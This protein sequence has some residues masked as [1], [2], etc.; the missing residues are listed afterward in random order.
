M[1]KLLLD[2]VRGHPDSTP[3]LILRLFRENFRRYMWRYAL[4]L[5]LMA[6][7]SAAT[8][9]SAWLIRDVINDVFVDQKIHMV[10]IFGGIFVAISIIKGFS[11]YGQTV[12]L[13]RIGNSIVAGMQ[14]QIFG[15]ILQLGMG[16]FEK[17]HSSQLIK[18]VSHNA[19]AARDLMNLIAT[20]FG[21]DLLT[22][23]GLVGV[24]IALD[25]VM[26]LL[27]LLIAPPIVVFMV[28]VVRR[29]RKLAAQEI[30]TGAA[31]IATAQE[32]TSGIRIIKSF[33][34]EEAMRERV[35]RVVAAVQDRANRM[36]RV[37]ASTGPLME[38]LGGIAIGLVI[39]YAGWQTIEAGRSPGDY[40][41]F[42]VAF[43][44]AYE[45]AKR[46]ARFRINLERSVVGVR[47]MYELIDSPP[48]EVDSPDAVALD[49][50][51]GQLA[52]IDVRF[53]YRAQ[54]PVLDGVSLEAAKGEVIALVGPS[55][56]GKTT[57]INLIQRFYS[58][59]SGELRVDGHDLK[60]VALSS[61]RRNIA[62][63]SQDT[64]L[65]TGTVRENLQVGRL[66][67]SESDIVK[68][69][70]AAGHDVTAV[71]RNPNSVIPD[72]PV[73]KADLATADSAELAAAVA[74]ADAVLSCLGPRSKADI[75]VAS[76]VHG[77]SSMPCKRQ[78]YDASSRSAQHRSAQ[79]HRPLGPG[80]PAT[81]P[82]TGSSC[83]LCSHPCSRRPSASTTPT[84]RS[85]KTS[86]GNV[87]WTGP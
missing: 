55:G 85:W 5:V 6:I 58:P 1:F 25:P 2:R 14:R 37:S 59:W 23:F 83:A 29:A 71:A 30:Q 19:G 12:V 24:M 4:A 27:T 79:S 87:R 9:L 56:G 28:K 16:H 43:L 54:E 81:I 51:E 57:I 77:P 41:A 36:A 84:S 62:F 73:C 32:T 64:F 31:V 46:L 21:R 70:K 10:W 47:M 49:R 63:V 7:T 67:A 61:L 69:A 76:T 15:R 40:M 11:A 52:L 20:S 66:E 18:Q 34:L 50:V 78:T 17:R 3:S 75:G 22:L 13:S 39:L 42:I 72:V 65:F 26:A 80:R 53:G 74:G 45:P 8:A 44:L 35:A 68:A 86:C 33:T 38:S 60:S 48:E 82:E